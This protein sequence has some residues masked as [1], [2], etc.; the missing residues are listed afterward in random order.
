MK[1][2]I[3]LGGVLTLILVFSSFSDISFSENIDNYFEADEQ[4]TIKENFKYLRATDDL[5]V[6][7]TKDLINT[8]KEDSELKSVTSNSILTKRKSNSFNK[9]QGSFYRTYDLK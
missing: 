1:N 6:L 2:I 8:I 9:H 7:S 5:N 3:K 4:I